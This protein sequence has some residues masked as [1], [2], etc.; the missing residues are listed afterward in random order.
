MPL[1]HLSDMVNHAYRHN[2]AVG[3]FGVGNQDFLEGVMKAAEI[4]RAPVI[5]NLIESH[6][7]VHDFDP[8]VPAV[9]AMARRAT[10]PVAINF[11]HGTSLAAAEHAISAGCNAIMVDT[12]ALPFSENLRQT[13]EIAGM[14]HACGVTVEGELG[15]VPGVEGESAE[16]HP[17]ELA[18]TS[19]VEARAFV[20][21][22]GVDCLAVS[23]GTVH[24]RMKGKP[25]LDYNRLA[26]IHEAVDIPLVIHGGTGLTD[27]QYRRLISH[28]VAKINYY[29]GLVDVAGQRV[30]DNANAG[31]GS[32][33]GALLAGVRDV[34]REEAERL[35]RIW[36]SGGRAAEVLAQCRPWQEVE[37]LVLYNAASE[38]SDSEVVSVMR[39]GQESMMGIPGVRNIRIGRSLQPDGKYHYCW[40]VT[41]SGQRA[42]ETYHSH[43]AQHDFANK[44][45]RSFA[46][47]R[48]KLDFEEIEPALLSLAIPSRQATV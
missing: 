44:V 13:R 30:R 24:G 28:G 27:E 19:A 31:Q 43:A 8:F 25:K 9:V 37:H 2:Y 1:V 36:G 5:L 34:V 6:F 20:E 42:I 39:E 16:E 41:L 40:L 10:V 32:G 17:G 48:L 26:K 38:Q 46:A 3:A 21:R 22:T 45:F 29:T 12:S 33:Y 18:Y 15:Y 35:I 47:D 23:I 4:S 11:D 14:G 7:S